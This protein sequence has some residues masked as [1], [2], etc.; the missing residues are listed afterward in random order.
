MA[1]FKVAAET[2]APA[3][4]GPGS[5]AVAFLDALHSLDPAGVATSGRIREEAL[6]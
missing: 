2:A 6:P 3:A 4:R 5:M 1:I